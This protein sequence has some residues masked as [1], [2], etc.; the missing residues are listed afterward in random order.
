MLSKVSYKGTVARIRVCY[1]K[2][3]ERGATR[4]A[5]KGLANSLIDVFQKRQLGVILLC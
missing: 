2:V 1:E 4:A 5:Q 3:C